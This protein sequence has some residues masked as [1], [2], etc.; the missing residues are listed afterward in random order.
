MIA[1][2][3]DTE[4][5]DPALAFAV[6]KDIT[7]TVAIR[8]VDYRGYRSFTY[9]LMMDSGPRILAAI[10]AAGKRGQKQSIEF[11]GI[12]VATG[13]AKIESIKKEV[14]FPSDEKLSSFS[15]KVETPLVTAKASP[16]A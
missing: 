4:G 6:E 8:D 10:P 15:Y 9:R 1:E 12:G 3:F 14:M 7:Y 16:S 13:K 5:T 2:I 11:I